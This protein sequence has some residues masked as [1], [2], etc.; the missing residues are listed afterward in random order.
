[1]LYWP[2]ARQR[3]ETAANG[4]FSM[5]RLLLL[6]VFCVALLAAGCGGTTTA[7]LQS[8][9]AAVV[10]STPV[11]KSEFQDLMGRAERS[12]KAQ[13]KSFPKAGSAEYEQL[14]TQALTYLVQQAE[15]EQEAD[16]MG[17]K[18]SDSDVD[19]RIEQLKK[20]FYGNSEKRYEKALAA[21]GVTAA[22]ARDVIRQQIISERVFKE[23][24]DNVKVSDTEAKAYYN[25]HKSQ[26]AQ[27]ET[28]IVRH[29][30]VPKKALA[31]SLY[32]QL[33]SGANFSQLAKKYSK[34]P[35]SASNGGKLT[36]SKGQTVPA[37]DKTAFALKNGELSQPIHTQYGYHIIQ[38]LSAIK[39]AQT[40][41]LSK[42]K[43]S[44]KLQLE[45]QRKNSVM[46]K[47]VEDKKKQ[48][49][50]S[51]IKYQVGYEPNPD[52]CASVTGATTTTSQ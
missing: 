45:Q 19:K 20:Q 11:T 33:K 31:D 46:T 41:P 5:K 2:R 12:Y 9:D 49:C 17:I 30:L 32:A 26:Y 28:R 52:P 14:K 44:I 50:K 21:Q 42:V 37:F 4:A 16:N 24:T 27:P 7:S 8:D 36:I 1:M 25:S 39:A 35:G 40:T 22:E 10:G 51:G 48:Y 23:V 47:W 43:Q 18:V 38:A 34:D 6:F 3:E 29:I 13:K 15:F